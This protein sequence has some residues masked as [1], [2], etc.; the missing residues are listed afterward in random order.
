MTASLNGIGPRLQVSLMTGK[1][2]GKHE[3]GEREGQPEQPTGECYL[4]PQISSKTIAYN[5]A[6]V[7]YDTSTEMSPNLSHV[8]QVP[9]K[10][11]YTNLG[12][13]LSKQ[14]IHALEN[15]RLWG[16]RAHCCVLGFQSDGLC[17]HKLL[18]A[19]IPHCLISS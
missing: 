16:P 17:D 9:R 4:M 19:F 8:G 11:S 14:S 12:I 18:Y 1:W 5:G 7:L 2:Q 13:C 10:S 6:T 15:L 3:G